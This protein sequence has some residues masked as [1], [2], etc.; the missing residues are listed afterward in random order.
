MS[1]KPNS[2]EMHLKS[3][4]STSFTYHS[5]DIGLVQTSEKVGK[6]QGELSINMLDNIKYDIEDCYSSKRLSPST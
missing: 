6:N 2:E 1:I 5:E 4:P 3:S